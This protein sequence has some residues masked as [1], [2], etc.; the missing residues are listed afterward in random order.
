[1]VT[2]ANILIKDAESEVLLYHHYDGYPEGV[3][4][5]LLDMM[6]IAKKEQL[7]SPKALAEFICQDESYEHEGEDA[8]IAPDIEFAYII[9]LT[10][11]QMEGLNVHIWG[12]A[13]F[14]KFILTNA[15]VHPC[16]R[17]RYPKMNIRGTKRY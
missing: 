9:N 8:T 11:K 3:G 5:E 10:T 1:M 4:N 12:C 2:R 7:Q 6:S 17:R 16:I 15:V 14:A 13:P